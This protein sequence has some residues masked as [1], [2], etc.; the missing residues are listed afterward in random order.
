MENDYW[1]IVYKFSKLLKK[2]DENLYNNKIC[3]KSALDLS[4]HGYLST[5][6]TYRTVFES[7]KEISLELCF[8][9]GLEQLHIECATGN[10]LK[11][12][13]ISTKVI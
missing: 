11:S 5:P 8:W 2:V 6:D 13:V 1:Q 12:K 10:G 9:H 3:P 4:I 7:V